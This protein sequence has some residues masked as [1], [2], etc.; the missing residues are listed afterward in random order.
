MDIPATARAQ[1]IAQLVRPRSITIVGAS[2]D[3]SKINGRPLKHLLGKGYAGRILPVNPKHTEIAG[4]PCYPAVAA[5]PEVPDLAVVVVPAAEVLASIRALGARGVRAAVVFSSGFGEMG[6]E[7]KA[8]ETELLVTAHA[9]GMVICGPNCLGFINAFDKVYATFSQY[10]DGETGAGPI[11]FVTQSGAFGTA[12]AALVRQRGL[13]LGY[14]MNTGNEADLSFCELMEAVLE[15]PRIR[16]AAGYLEGLHDGAALVR[17]AK[18]CQALGKPLV[19]IKV[20]RMAAGARAAASHTGALAVQDAVFDAVARQYGILRAR[21]EEQML[22]MLEALSQPRVPMGRGLGIVTQSGGAGVMMAD[23]A[24][25]MGLEV[26]Q[27]APG[28]RARLAEVVPV[29][30]AI[31]NPVDVTGQFV[32]RPEL[33]RDAVIRLME[34]PQVHVC[35]VWLQLMTAHVERLVQIFCEIGRDTTKPFFVCWVAAPAQALVQLRAAGIVV[36]RAGECAVEAAAAL[37]H[38]H[39]YRR[40]AARQEYPDQ[41]LPAALPTDWTPGLQDS[42]RAVG[43]LRAAGIPMAEVALAQDEAQAVAL[44][45]AIGRPVAMKIESQDIAHKTELGGVHLAVDG[46]PAVCTAFGELLARARHALPQAR[47]N[48]VLVQPMVYARHELVVGVQRDPVFGMVVM[49]GMGGILVEVLKDVALRRAPFGEDEG[50]RMLAELR[51]G[52]VLDGVRGQ[53]AVDRRQIAALLSRLSSWAVSMQLVLAELDLNPVMLTANG[54]VAV[55]CVMV[56]D[57]LPEG[58]RPLPHPPSI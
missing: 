24:E 36:F 41:S 40:A 39:A 8:L 34:D 32:A 47:L 54:P 9:C 12:I 51:A 44:W 11:A 2:A 14:F 28:T 48:G 38:H 6:P 26:A 23:R 22:D 50:L 53:P 1:A 7:G 45:R 49:V 10:A 31:G 5:L 56:F 42:V 18:R 52:A 35:L 21:N 25:E 15:D 43:W 20:G 33:F 29:F 16:V 37:V 27:L 46:E 58:V 13:G 4:L 57:P 30:G 55:D 17:L 3:L 19:L